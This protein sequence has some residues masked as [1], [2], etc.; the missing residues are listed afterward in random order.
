MSDIRFSTFPRT[1]APQTFVRMI[2]DAFKAHEA[3]ISTLTLPKGKVSDE[4]LAEVSPSL[5][6]IGFQVEASKARI[7][8]LERPVFYG[9]N[10]EPSLKYEVDAYQP[11]WRCGLEVE[12][13]RAW[14]GNAVYRDIVL[15]T[16]M[17]D[18]DHL[19]L[20]VPLQYRFNVGSRQTVSRDYDN[21]LRLVET[22][23]AH[24]RLKLPYRMTVIGY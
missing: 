14:M 16:V 1:E 15:S 11:E 5:Q 9:E 8:K 13:G 17:V 4:V 7:D 22:L 3:A 23:F 6:A 10:G 18:V 24:T 21:T 2:V 19:V 20:A 12:A